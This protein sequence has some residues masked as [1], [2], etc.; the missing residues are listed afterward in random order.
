MSSTGPRRSNLPALPTGTE[1][2]SYRSYEEAAEAVETLADAGFPLPNV[3]IVGTDVHVVDRILGKLTPARVAMAGAGQGLTW[4]LLMS[5]IFVVFSETYSALIP[6]MAIGAGVGVGI[7]ISMFSW[8]NRRGRRN[9]A[10]QS[11][12]VAT[13]YALLVEEQTD[14]AYQLLQGSRGNLNRTQ[15]RRVRKAVSSGP[16]EYGSRADE[17]PRFGVRLNEEKDGQAS[18]ADQEQ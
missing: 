11:Q 13:R 4:G 7:L 5:L 6:I 17:Q 9:F 3:S 18:E 2:A 14:R 10:S 12:I 8:M 16:T 1:V 15:H